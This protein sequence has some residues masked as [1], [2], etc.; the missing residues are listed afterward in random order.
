M[1]LKKDQTA[2]SFWTGEHSGRNK[3]VALAAVVTVAIILYALILTRAASS[4]VSISPSTATLSGNAQV[5]TESDGTKSLVFQAPATPPPTTPPPTTPPATWPTRT[6]VGA[7]LGF[8]RTMS[9]PGIDDTSF[10]KNNGF[11]GSGTASDPYLV[12]R[13]SFTSQVTLGNWDSSNLTGKWVKFTNCSFAGEPNFPTPGGSA[14]IFARDNAPFFI[15]EDSNIKVGSRYVEKTD[16]NGKVV[17]DP[18][19]GKPV[20][21]S[22][23]GSS[24]FGIFSYVPFQLRRSVVLGANIL[25]GF[26]TE[27][28]ERTGVVIEGNYMSDVYSSKDDHTDI[29]N[30]N[31]H[32]SHVTVR[33]NFLDG[34]RTNFNAAGPSPAPSV[35]VVTNGFGVYDDPTGSSAGIFENWTVDHNY[36]TNCATL[37]LSTTSKSR[38]LDPFVLTNNIFGDYTYLSFSGRTPSTQSGNQTAAG[39]ALSF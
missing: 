3:V 39:K 19:T 2:N 34:S 7:K 11:P 18:N 17:I 14:G 29:I 26:E 30:G 15:V 23:N 33:N 25:V 4:Y 21:L 6:S 8:L 1:T 22:Y 28:S 36:I 37:F 35:T 32:A 12:D 20:V 24:N 10:F 9:G 16:E 13:V 31:F 27:R 5:V 38:F